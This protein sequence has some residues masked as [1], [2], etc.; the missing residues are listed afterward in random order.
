MPDQQ[1][2][3]YIELP[4]TNLEHTKAFFTEVFGWSFQDFGTEYSAF[5]SRGGNGGFYQSELCSDTRNG[6]TLVVLFSDDLDRCLARVEQAGGI[7]VKPV[8]AFPGGRRF[9]FR[10]PSGNELAV[11][12]DR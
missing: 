11:W 5:S 4:A 8:F 7:I 2:T 9:H 6:A 12:S 10:E 1:T 3:H